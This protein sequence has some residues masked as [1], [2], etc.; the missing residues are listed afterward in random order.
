MG[1][2]NLAKWQLSPP[3]IR[4]PRVCDVHVHAHACVCKDTF[5]LNVT[6]NF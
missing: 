2:E 3:T 1:G 5:L 4:S 6:Q